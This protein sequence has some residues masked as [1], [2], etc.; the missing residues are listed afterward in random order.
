[1]RESIAEA[2]KTIEDNQTAQ[3]LHGLLSLKA[4]STT[5]SS[6]AATTAT[7]TTSE[8][9]SLV[10][11]SD[12]TITLVSSPGLPNIII[13]QPQTITQTAAISPSEPATIHITPTCSTGLPIPGLAS[14]TLAGAAQQVIESAN[15]KKGSAE[16]EQLLMHKLQQA[17]QMNSE[18]FNVC[19][20]PP[21]FCKY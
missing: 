6:A 18:V 15:Q 4:D 19:P 7:K 10:R 3:A 1:M 21:D 5:E 2:C 12:H 20:I 13:D 9:E 16:S 11:Q 8:C 14:A 17:R